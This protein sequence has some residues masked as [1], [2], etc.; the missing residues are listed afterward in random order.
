MANI[1]F[2]GEA[3]ALEWAMPLD[4]EV[5]G[6]YYTYKLVMASTGRTSATVELILLQGTQETVIGEDSFVIDSTQYTPYQGQFLS[7]P[8]P[9]Q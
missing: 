9:R 7:L 4:N 8:R 1:I 2:T 6:D 3:M 5:L